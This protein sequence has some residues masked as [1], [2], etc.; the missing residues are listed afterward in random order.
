MNCII[1]TTDEPFYL[2]VTIQKILENEY[3]KTK[4][5]AVVLLPPTTKKQTWK[6][7]IKEQLNFGLI[8]FIYRG[9]QFFVYKIL[10]K[11]NL[12][13]KGRFFSVASVAKAFGVPLI[14]LDYINLSQSINILKNLKPD[15]FISIS[16]SQLFSKTVISLPKY[17]TIN[18]HN[19]PLPKY[20]GL[21]PSFW[22]LKNGEKKTATT[23]HYMTEKIDAGDIIVQK[24][25][26]IRP[27][28]T[29]DDV[30]KK[31]KLN[32]VEALYETLSLFEKY[33][34]MPPTKENRLEEAT[35]FTFPSKADVK[36]FKKA[37][38]KL[39]W[40]NIY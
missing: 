19:A 37:G 25:V 13:I 34:G 1:I 2:P 31:T 11:F 30:I 7:I 23:V 27:D 32:T 40:K 38:R 29:L 15:L 24:E 22:V 16:A 10:S 8:Y 6:D 18:V 3:L 17:G 20:Q 4:I 21:M 35:Y 9:L 26:Q 5:G 28:D 33:K 36:D 14:K 12:K 39:L